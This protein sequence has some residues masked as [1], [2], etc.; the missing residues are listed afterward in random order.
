MRVVKNL[1]TGH[2]YLVG[3][4]TISH[5]TT[6]NQATWLALIYNVGVDWRRNPAT[7]VI[8]VEGSQFVSMIRGLGISE[9][10]AASV[11]SP[12]GG[13]WSAERVISDKV[14]QLLSRP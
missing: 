7:M 6:M 11:V 5:M 13:Y 4:Q 12:S 10:T 8:E 14:D 2:V 9:A 3:F 1:N